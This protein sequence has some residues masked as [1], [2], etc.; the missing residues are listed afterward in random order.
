MRSR[1][2]LFFFEPVTGMKML[3]MPVIMG[4]PVFV[5]KWRVMMQMD[6]C[7]GE[8]EVHSDKHHDE[9]KYKRVAGL[10]PED[11]EREDD[12]QYQVNAKERSCP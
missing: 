10:L 12:T 4:V 1:L 9:C 7:L 8:D 5:N 2:D 11:Q 3:M 6:V